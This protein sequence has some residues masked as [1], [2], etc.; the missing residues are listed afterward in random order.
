[1]TGEQHKTR[2]LDAD[3]GWYRGGCQV[4]SWLGPYRRKRK[5][6]QS[7]ARQHLIDVTRYPNPDVHGA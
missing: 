3:Y 7:D 5:S 6:A 2:A 1:V 4:C